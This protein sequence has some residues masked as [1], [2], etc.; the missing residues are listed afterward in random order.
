MFSPHYSVSVWC[1][2]GID[3]R[4]GAIQWAAKLESTA[5]VLYCWVRTKKWVAQLIIYLLSLL[6]RL[7]SSCLLWFQHFPLI[8]QSFV[9]KIQCFIQFL[10]GSWLGGSWRQTS[11]EP[12]R[13]TTGLWRTGAGG[14]S[15]FNSCSSH[16]SHSKVGCCVRYGIWCTNLSTVQLGC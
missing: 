6:K 3:S 5:V 2:G 15:E 16:S 9:G 10:F 12:L 4:E 13:T 11:W 14:G 1:C 8:Q 7:L